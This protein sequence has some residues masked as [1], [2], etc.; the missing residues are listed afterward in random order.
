MTS[1]RLQMRVVILMGD[2]DV[3]LE[4]NHIV[5]LTPNCRVE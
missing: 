5:A 2:A 4:V 1:G 3:Q